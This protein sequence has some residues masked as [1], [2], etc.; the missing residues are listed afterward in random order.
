MKQYRWSSIPSGE[1]DAVLRPPQTGLADAIRLSVLDIIAAVRADGDAALLRFTR[2]FD[3][4]D[5][6]ELKLDALTLQPAKEAVS[7][8]LITALGIAARNIERFH[9]AQRPRDVSVETMPG[10]VCEQRWIPLST[11]GLYV[12]GGTAPLFSTVLML[13][14]PARL[15]GCERVIICTPPQADGTLHPAII[16]AAQIAGITEIYTVGGAQ[17]IAAMAYGTETIPKVDKIF[18]P[19]NAYVTAAKM[20]VSLDGHGAAIDLPA[21]PTEVMVIANN[22]ITAAWVA[23]DL[24]AQAEH[25]VLADVV[26]VTNDESYAAEVWRETQAQ[27]PKLPRR[28]IAEKALEH[29]RS[30][31]VEDWSEAAEVANRYAPEHLLLQGLEPEALLPQVRHAGS[32][33]L[34]SHTPDPLGDYASGTNHVLP[35]G[36]AARAY[37]GVTLLSFMKSI[38]VQ[39]ASSASLAA[40][41]PTVIALAEGEGLEGHANAVR[42]RLDRGDSG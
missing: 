15:A 8:E 14:I 27:A 25:D 1:R 4:V 9:E 7:K 21:G 11:V 24:L 39:R 12:P 28:S 5:L 26:F 17:A 42:I 34:G 16:A 41:A 2:Q 37:S 31:I 18:G 32:I 19:G 29:A 30:I 36:R 22:T 20:Q 6:R 38:T 13:G 10:L 33:F 40:I 35:T 23:A 3:G